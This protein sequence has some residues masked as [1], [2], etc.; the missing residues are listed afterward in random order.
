MPSQSASAPFQ[1]QQAET[2]WLGVS[3]PSDMED[4][5]LENSLLQHGMIKPN[6]E[7]KCFIMSVTE[8]WRDDWNEVCRLLASRA[9]NSI[10]VAVLPC[11]TEP[12][13][14]EVIAS[15]QPLPALNEINS[16]LWL[17]EALDKKTVEPYF[18]PVVDASS[19][20]LGFESLARIKSDGKPLSGEKIIA[21]SH[22]LNIQHIVDHLLHNRTVEEYAAHKLSGLLFVNLIPG[23]NRKP[24]FYC[25]ALTQAAENG[26]LKPEETVLDI[27]NIEQIADITGLQKLV[28]YAETSGFSV[29][30]ESI[31]SAES[32]AKLI[33]ALRPEYI[34]LDIK[35]IADFCS[36]ADK[37]ELKK[38]LAI[39]DDYACKV[40][41]VGVETPA[42]FEQL[43]KAG[44]CLF[45]GYLFGKP[46]PAKSLKK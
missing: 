37:G 13:V 5:I 29:A 41:A 31:T 9:D 39:A 21:A 16:N 18:Q 27:T 46:E 19:K 2:Y 33:D 8:S 26:I 11:R 17:L 10:R 40:I 15:S 24:S 28:E 36:D 1:R 23:F 3:L 20:Q 34:R 43:K 7:K 6:E 14:S 30:L 4:E 12:S 45:Q 32:A 44:V 35:L 25:D 38:I 42:C 22:M